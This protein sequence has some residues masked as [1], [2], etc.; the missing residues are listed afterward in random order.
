MS[1]YY[2]IACAVIQRELSHFAASSEHDHDFNF[3]EQGLHNT[4]DLL[5]ERLQ[6]AIDAAPNCDAI[7]L[8]YCLCCNGTVGIRARKTRL[9]VPRGHDCITLLLGS[10]EKYREYFDSHPGTYWYSPGWIDTGTQPGKERYESLLAE[11]TEKYG[12]DNAQYLMEVE[13]GWQEKYT[14]AAYVDIAFEDTTKYKKY[15]KQCASYLGWNFE[16][17]KGD[18]KL[19]AALLEGEW[20]SSEFLIVEPGEVVI[21]TNDKGIIGKKRD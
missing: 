8:G 13:Q 10:K 15:A 21:A 3:L 9:V 11:Y 2:T 5:R 1:R 7:L 4:P 19:I 12:E 18:K 14:N 16:E 17:V 20:D 6:E